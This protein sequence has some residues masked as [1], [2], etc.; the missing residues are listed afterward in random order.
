MPALPARAAATASN[1]DAVMSFLDPY[2][3][4]RRI[5]LIGW[6]RLGVWSL[7]LVAVGLLIWAFV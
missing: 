1:R 4:N 6:M 2:E 3:G 5:S 7:I